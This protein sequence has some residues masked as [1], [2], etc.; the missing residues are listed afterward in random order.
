MNGIT[1]YRGRRGVPINFEDGL[2]SKGVDLLEYLYQLSSSQ[3]ASSAKLLIVAREYLSTGTGVGYSASDKIVGVTAYDVSTS[4]AGEATQW[5]N[6]TTK[7]LI[8]APAAAHLVQTGGQST[9]TAVAP[10]VGYISEDE[11]IAQNNGS[12]YLRGDQLRRYDLV[13]QDNGV[14]VEASTWYNR[15]TSPVSLLAVA[16]PAADLGRDRSWMMGDLNS[17]AA[18]SD[19]MGDINVIGGL[20]ALILGLAAQQKTLGELAAKIST[21]NQASLAKLSDLIS[22]LPPALGGSD[23]TK[24]LPVRIT[25]MP[26]VAT[27]GSGGSTN[28]TT[29]DSSTVT[30]RYVAI[31]AGTGYQV[32]ETLVCIRVTE[33]VGGVKT[34]TETWM[35]EAN[36]VVLTILPALTDLRCESS[37]VGRPRLAV[38]ELVDGQSFV[39]TDL[40]ATTDIVLSGITIVPSEGRCRV[41]LSDNSSFLLEAGEVFE[42]STDVDVLGDGISTE[43]SVYCISG[44]TKVI[45]SYHQF[46]DPVVPV[47]TLADANGTALT[48]TDGILTI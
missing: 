29:T 43:L 46:V 14:V 35:N 32:G 6:V 11:F 15:S 7:K 4:P 12:G 48:D 16:P 9:S 38:M 34:T 20:R 24:A 22:K 27:T 13:S 21:D 39:A 10:R 5:F 3:A 45:Y 2:Y 17:P 36:R 33:S 8:A 19:G 37:P 23:D 41:L 26:A 28:V 47:G 30:T 18:A 25:T 44:Y 1:N 31:K 42:F 40:E